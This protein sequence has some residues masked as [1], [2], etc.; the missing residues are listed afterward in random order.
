VIRAGFGL[1]AMG[2][3]LGCFDKTEELLDRTFFANKINK[4]ALSRKM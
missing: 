2:T 3:L 4:K 1:G